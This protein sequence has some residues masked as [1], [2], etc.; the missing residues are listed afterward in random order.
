MKWTYRSS[1][2]PVFTL[3]LALGVAGCNKTADQN[4]AQEQTGQDQGD[5]ANANLAPVT[6]AGGDNGGA[7]QGSS[8]NESAAQTA[9]APAQ[10]APA[11]AQTAPAPAQTQASYS[12]PTSAA[13]NDQ[14]D[15]SE[16]SYD[17]QPEDYAQEPP[18]PLPDY[19]QPAI[20]GP[21]YIWTPGYWG[22]AS[23]GYYWVPGVW[24]A[25]PYYGALWT[26]PYWGF[27]GGRYGFIHGYWGRYVGFYGGV[28]YGYGYIGRGYQGGYWHGN[29]FY[30]NRTVNNVSNVHITNVY[31]RT[32]VNN[33][34]VTNYNRAS[35]NGGPHGVQLRPDPRRGSRVS[36][37]ARATH[38]WTAP[39]AA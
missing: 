23:A 32:I 25:P 11:P 2:L 18:P 8:G 39:A 28:N 12:Q 9:P 36:R 21:G 29:D 35:Y 4:A 19:E 38:E 24:V 26:P 22:W 10:T 6:D 16:A 30:Y 20:P 14:A 27:F 7:A 34:N 31:N 5:P 3:A 13:N 37:T 1:A 17:P 15:Y 33:I